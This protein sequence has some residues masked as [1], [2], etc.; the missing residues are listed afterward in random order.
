M[1][2]G[3]LLAHCSL[4][5]TPAD[6]WHSPVVIQL[7]MHLGYWLPAVEPVSARFIWQIVLQCDVMKIATEFALVL[8]YITVQ[9][10]LCLRKV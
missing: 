1:F 4:F 5:R 2:V 7:N 8:I 3:E 9:W 6:D 10:M